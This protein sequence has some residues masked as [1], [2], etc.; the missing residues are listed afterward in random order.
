MSKGK[1]LAYQNRDEDEDDEEEEYDEE[2]EELE[3]EDEEEDEEFD[4]EA[5]ESRGY[6]KSGKGGGGGKSNGGGKSRGG[7][8]SSKKRRRYDDD[9]DDDDDD[10]EED[11]KNSRH[12]KR[13]RDAFFDDQAEVDD[14]DEYESTD[15]EEDEGE[16]FIDHS[17]EIPQERG[18]GR[19]MEHPHWLDR[20]DE[21]IDV[22]ECERI[23]QEWYQRYEDNSG[24]YAEDTNDVE[25]Q[26]LLPSVK[27][28]KLWI[29]KCAIGREREAAFCLMQKCIDQGHGMNIK[30]AIALDYLKNYVY[31]EADK[32][33]HVKEACKGL[34]MLN[35]TKVMLVPIKE[36]SD[37]LTVKGK[38]MD[39]VKDMWVRV[40]IGIY[41]GDLA[42]VVNVLDMRQRVMVK[43][44]PRVDLQ[45]IADKLEGRRVTKKAIVPTPRLINIDEARKLN[46]PV[47]T[48]RGRST[49]M[50]FDVFDGKMFSEGFLYKT[51]SMKSIS[52]QNIQPSFDEL[53]KFSEPGQGV[54]GIMSMS[55]SVANGRKCPF[56]KGDAVIVVNGDLMNLMGWVEKVDEDNVH[57]RPKRK[58]L[59]TT[60]TVNGKYVSK[61]F[62]PGDHVK[63]VSGAHEGATGMVITVNSN[64]L[65]IISDATKENI[66]VFADHVVDSSE[67]TSGVAR[68]GDYELHDLV[69][70]DNMSF[71]VIIPLESEA[72]HILKGD[73]DRPEVVLVKLREI[74]YKIER[75]N[76]AQDRWKNTVSVKDVVKILMGPC[77]GKQGPVEHILKGILFIKDRHHMEHAGYICAKAQSC[78][79][80]GGSHS[81][82]VSPPLRYGASRDLAHIP[83]SP[84]RCPRGGPPFNSGGR[85]TGGRGHD[86]FVG[87]TIKIRVG[88]YKGCRGRVVSVNGQLVRVELESQ[89]KTFTVNRNEVS[90]NM[91]VST[92]FCETP[93]RGIGSETPMHRAQTPLRPCMTPSR[94]QGGETQIQIGI[95]TPMRDQAWDPYAAPTPARDSW[96]DGNPGSWETP[97]ARSN[98]ASVSASPN[99]DSGWGSCGEKN[100]GS[101]GT[102]LARSNEASV[103]ASPNTDSSWGSWGEKNPGS[104]G[105]PLARSNE[106]S[107]SASPNTDSGWGTWGEKN[108]GSWGTTPQA[109]QGTPLSRSNKAPVSASPTTGSGWGSWGNQN[110]GSKGTSPK[111]QRVS[112]LARPNESPP[113]AIT[114]GSGWGSW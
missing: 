25:Q 82:V 92:S 47:D 71:G 56:M 24:D 106:A 64:V 51:L 85:H 95:R 73:P 108:P 3:E 42:K 91:A 29:V 84:R 19:R 60:V 35:S 6:S 104:W 75:K 72:L 63:V 2:V 20:G 111:C 23:V 77:K 113:P 4:V 76:T 43:L 31:I 65:V 53:Q 98:E 9:D 48:R 13:V 61:Y 54:G 74:K 8:G 11:G 89:M 88:N 30:S 57:I 68:I 67:V 52:Y 83:P 90:D 5:Y 62:K 99:T 70:L 26:A 103:S 41:K 79:V 38:T 22:A 10:D 101:W 59:H 87:S 49:R 39:I 112:P 18:V 114:T 28:P 21:E 102:P 100:P 105:T 33:A 27:D 16:P 17:D 55:T 80:M 97:L 12:K 34:K 7:G 32:E 14:E 58:D 78:I 46:I 93:Q 44:V 36:M 15:G 110:P 37:V 107:V 96:E 81:K 94:D 1:T 86:S 66:R 40:K 50:H 109:Q 45:A 69:M